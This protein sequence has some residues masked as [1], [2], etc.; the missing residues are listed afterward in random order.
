MVR[1]LSIGKEETSLGLTSDHTETMKGVH[2]LQLCAQRD[3]KLS[4]VMCW[5]KGRFK[6]L[7]QFLEKIQAEEE[8]SEERAY[9]VNHALLMAIRNAWESVAIRILTFNNDRCAG[10][11]DQNPIWGLV[12]PHLYRGKHDF[13]VE[14]LSTLGNSGMYYPTERLLMGRIRVHTSSFSPAPAFLPSYVV[15]FP[16]N[17]LKL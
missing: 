3:K 5:R 12:Q 1:L 9:Y 6:R 15:R 17:H 2:M 4:K 16:C 10:G 13:H 11:G 8:S 14:H 7:Y